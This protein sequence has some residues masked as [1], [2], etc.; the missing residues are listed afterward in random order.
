MICPKCKSSNV[1][2]QVVTKTD[3][4]TKNR[5]FV[6]WFFLGWWWIPFKW[7]FFTIPALI[8]KL[9]R[10]ARYKTKTITQAKCVCQNCGHCW[11][12]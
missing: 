5:S 3:L 7:A 6:W 4:V 8:L 2:V 12:A 10:P 11:N 1:S 9:F